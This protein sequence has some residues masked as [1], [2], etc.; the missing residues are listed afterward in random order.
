MIDCRCYLFCMYELLEKTI[1]ETAKEC[2]MSASMT[3]RKLKEFNIK[4]RTKSEVK[5]GK[6]N[7]NWKDGIYNCRCYL[8]CVYE[9]LGRS[10]RQI[11]KECLISFS[12]IRRRL[13]KF[14]I[15]IRTSNRI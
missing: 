8:F 7:P 10:I 2:K 4:I 12:V 11:A 14:N 6:N 15:E 3:Y 1:I 9:L 5:T 13:K